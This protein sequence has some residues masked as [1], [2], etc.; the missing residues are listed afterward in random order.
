M[1]LTVR[2]PDGVYKQLKRRKEK[3]KSHVSL[4]SLIVEAI[5]EQLKPK[6]K[7]GWG[8]LQPSETEPLCQ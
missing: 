6:G 1:N 4:N 2:I 8:K 7:L 3:A 5:V